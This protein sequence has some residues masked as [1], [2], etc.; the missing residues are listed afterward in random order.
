MYLVPR[1][2]SLVHAASDTVTVDRNTGVGTADFLNDSKVTGRAE[3]FALLGEDY[4]DNV[5]PQMNIEQVGSRVVEDAGGRRYVEF[6]IQTLRPRQIPLESSFRVLLDTDRDGSIDWM[7]FNDDLAWFLGSFGLRVGGLAVQGTQRMLAVEVTTQDPFGFKFPVGT[8]SGDFAY[9]A[10]AEV[11]LDTRLIILRAPA[12]SLG[13][14]KDEPIAFDAV[15]WHHA[16]FDEVRGGSRWDAYESVPDG[17]IVFG[18]ETNAPGRQSGVIYNGVKI[19]DERM[20]FDERQLAFD[21]DRW[22][23]E[24]ERD[25]ENFAEV[26]KK[27]VTGEHVLDKLWAVY[28]FNTPDEFFEDIIGDNQVLTI[29]EGSV[30]P[31]PTRPAPATATPEEPTPDPGGATPTTVPTPSGFD[32]VGTIFLPMSAKNADIRAE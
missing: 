22:T 20:T 10:F 25:G 18:T 8:Y 5:G 24:V 29:E 4:G 1:G 16:N 26:T 11:T 7:V 31:P 2:T 9:A 23:V 3:L 30:A 15:V 17:G 19:T 21:V 12:E 13:Y 27:E 6:A 32:P 14:G 28:T